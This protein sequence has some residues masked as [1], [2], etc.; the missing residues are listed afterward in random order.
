[1]RAVSS[2]DLAD[3]S[4]RHVL[5]VVPPV[6]AETRRTG[7]NRGRGRPAGVGDEVNGDLTVWDVRGTGR[8]GDG[9]V[10]RGAVL[11]RRRPAPRREKGL[12]PLAQPFWS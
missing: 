11:H 3:S 8:S 1:M 5:E 9:A 12:S 6:E 10:S 7:G 2:A 4:A